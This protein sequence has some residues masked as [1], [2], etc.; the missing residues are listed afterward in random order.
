MRIDAL[1][2]PIPINN[3][4]MKNPFVPTT[5]TAISRSSVPEFLCN[6][7]LLNVRAREHMIMIKAKND[8]SCTFAKNAHSINPK[9]SN[10]K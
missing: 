9:E 8:I 5:L 2:A 10:N 7:S 6:D 3:A 1:S 4:K